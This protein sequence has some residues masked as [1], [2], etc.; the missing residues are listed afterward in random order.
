[1]AGAH[2]VIAFE[3]QRRDSSRKPEQSNIKTGI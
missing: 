3:K 2:P 1:M